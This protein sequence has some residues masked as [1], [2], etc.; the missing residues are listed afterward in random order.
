M[1]LPS[2]EDSRAGRE[3]VVVVAGATE[4]QEARV[5]TLTGNCYY[6]TSCICIEVRTISTLACEL[7]FPSVV[8]ETTLCTQQPATCAGDSGAPLLVRDAEGQ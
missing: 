3:A 2:S 8:R 7:Q 4:L 5:G 1:C 6:Y